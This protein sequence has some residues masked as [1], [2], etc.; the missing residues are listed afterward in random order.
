MDVRV[1]IDE[2]IVENETR[3]NKKVIWLR[4]FEHVEHIQGGAK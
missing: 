1:Y 4:W 3:A 2:K